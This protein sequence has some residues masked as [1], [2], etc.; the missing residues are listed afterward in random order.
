[1]DIAFNI[2]DCRVG[3]AMSD[4]FSPDYDEVLRGQLMSPPGAHK[5]GDPGR[6]IPGSPRRIEAWGCPKVSLVPCAAL[7]SML[8]L[9][10]VIGA[11]LATCLPIPV[12]FTLVWAAKLHNH[13]LTAPQWR[14]P[15]SAILTSLQS[16]SHR[17]DGWYIGQHQEVSLKYKWPR[18]QQVPVGRGYFPS[19]PY[20]IW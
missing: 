12:M 1:M 17:L 7:V 18:F 4:W 2:D 14:H 9:L 19:T 10:W 3:P 15:L 11:G 16:S 8:D 13:V 20:S 5:E 6:E